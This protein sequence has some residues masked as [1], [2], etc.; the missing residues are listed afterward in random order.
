[1]QPQLHRITKIYPIP[2]VNARPIEIELFW[3]AYLISYS[4]MD[5]IQRFK[6]TLFDKCGH[7]VN[8]AFNVVQDRSF[9]YII[10]EF[11]IYQIKWDLSRP[12]NDEFA[13]L[14]ALED[15]LSSLIVIS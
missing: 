13:A 11:Y 8:V 15:Y 1:M 6:N 12:Y 10:T 5:S 14:E 9:A 3:P 2:E 7:Y 4:K